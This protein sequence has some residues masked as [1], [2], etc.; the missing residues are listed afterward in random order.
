MAIIARSLVRAFGLVARQIADLLTM[1]LDYPALA[2]AIS[3]NLEIIDPAAAV[4]GIPVE[5]SVVLIRWLVNFM[6]S[7]EAQLRLG[8]SLSSN[9]SV[10]SGAPSN[11]ITLVGRTP[12]SRYLFYN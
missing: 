6:D 10:P 8:I 3:R 12:L 4:S 11:H 7:T 5:R 1:Q 9:A 2:P